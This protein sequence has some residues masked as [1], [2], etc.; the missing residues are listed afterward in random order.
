MKR[1]GGDNVSA[2]IRESK[3]HDGCRMASCKTKGRYMNG[4]EN[5]A[6]RMRPVGVVRCE[7]K[8][9]S[10][11]ATE[12]GLVMEERMQQARERHAMIMSMVSELVLDEEYA[13]SL[14]GIEGFSHVLVLYWPHLVDPERRTLKKVRPMG[15]K[16]MPEQGVFATCSPARPNSVLVT[17]VRLLE[18]DGA[19]LRV[20]GLEAVDGSPILDIKPYTPHYYMVRGCGHPGLDGA[21]AGGDR[22]GGVGRNGSFWTMRSELP[23]DLKME[24]KPVA[25][26]NGR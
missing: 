19:C 13:S 14:D 8:D 2:R 17:A 18:R 26:C 22:P 10:L 1:G 23:V 24:L 25:H 11:R 20:R 4:G 9:P 7:L 6:I 12:D 21:V 5:N 3:P 16:D 15:R